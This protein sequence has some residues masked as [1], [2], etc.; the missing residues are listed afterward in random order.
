MREWINLVEGK[1]KLRPT[2]EDIE[3]IRK[4]RHEIRTDEGGGGMCHFVSECIHNKFGWHAESG[5]LLD[6]NGDV[7]MGG[8]H[9]WNVLPDGAILDATADQ[10]GEGRDIA[11][12]EPDDPDYH[13]YA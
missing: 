5:T 1:V 11:I 7:I 3:W 2:A 9:V 10:I 6:R 12:I 13:R 8:G 4:L